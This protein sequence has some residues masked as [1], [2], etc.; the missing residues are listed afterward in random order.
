MIE[1]VLIPEERMKKLRKDEKWKKELKRFSDVKIEL[2]GEIMIEGDNPI[3]VLRIKEIIKAFGRGFEFKNALNLID[4]ENFLE[5][6][7]VREFT[8][9]SKKRQV[10]LKGRVIGTKGKTKSMIEEYTNTKIAVYGKTISIIGKWNDVKL[11]RNAIEMLLSGTAHNTVYRFL[12][13][14]KVN[15]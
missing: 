13:T 2:N 6:I 14:H 4:E 11:A 1:F 12:E 3:Q 15:S 8:G 10:V 5:T 9:K 7:D